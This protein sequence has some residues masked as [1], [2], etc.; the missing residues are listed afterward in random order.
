[1]NS[2]EPTPS[3]ASWDHE[4][5]GSAEAAPLQETSLQLTQSRCLIMQGSLLSVPLSLSRKSRAVLHS[6]TSII[7][8]KVEFPLGGLAGQQEQEML[9]QGP[10]EQTG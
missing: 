4:P 1:M 6:R 3:S 7:Q 8:P 10:D 5:G 2:P 9:Y